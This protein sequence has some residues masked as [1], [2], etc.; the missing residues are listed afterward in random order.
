MGETAAS[1]LQGN[2]SIAV[3]PPANEPDYIVVHIAGEVNYPGVFTLREGARVNDALYM[4]GGET[5]Y[6]N[7]MRVNLAAFLQDA[8][9]III[10]A[11]GDYTT[12]VF[13]FGGNAQGTGGITASGLIN[14]NTA[15]SAQLQT[16][17]GI[18]PARAQNIIDFRE[19]HGNF[20]SVDELI[21]ISGIGAVTLENLRPHVTV[22]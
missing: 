7:L 5:E 22:E 2:D 17:S 19:T 3:Y 6:A 18:G 1:N 20:S 16:I 11:E 14:L 21:H 12:A 8:M 10:P 4:A 9:Q 13:V 15:T